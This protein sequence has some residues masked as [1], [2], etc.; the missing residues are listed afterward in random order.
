MTIVKNRLRH[1]VIFCNES[2]MEINLFKNKEEEKEF[3]NNHW[4]KKH[5]LFKDA[6]SNIF[7]IDQDTIDE[8]LKSDE[9]ESRAV[10]NKEKRQLFHGPFN[11]DELIE[12][13]NNYYNFIIHDLN[14]LFKPIEN[15]QTNLNI[16]SQWE[17]DDVICT[18][19]NKDMSLGAHYD[20]YNVFI[21]QASGDRKWQLQYNPINEWD[22]N[23]EI[24]V[25]KSFKSEIEIHLSPGDVLY[26]P[27]KVAHH[28]ISLNQSLSYSIGFKALRFKNLLE[29]FFLKEIENINEDIIFNNNY[30]SNEYPESLTHFFKKNISQIMTTEKIVNFLKSKTTSPKYFDELNEEADLKLNYQKDTYTKWIYDSN[31][32]EIY[33]NGERYTYNENELDVVLKYL[34]KSSFEEFKFDKEDLNSNIIKS[35]INKGVFFST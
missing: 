30:P 14:T 1:C 5:K 8:L 24:K 10:V 15:L 33:I 31:Q 19:S 12:F 9:I 6:V 7:T 21:V 34:N 26:I 4:N 20:P 2:Y 3:I 29:E 18:Y 22:Q 25:L 17:F 23:E 13:K 16:F 35:L 27:T 32:N 11:D 28:G